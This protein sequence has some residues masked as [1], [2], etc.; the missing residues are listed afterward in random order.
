MRIISIALVLIF[1]KKYS[2][3][4]FPR[5]NTYWLA[6]CSF[7]CCNQRFVSQLGCRHL[8]P[9]TTPASTSGETSSALQVLSKGL[10]VRVLLVRSWA[11]NLGSSLL[12]QQF[13]KCCSEFFEGKSDDLVVQVNFIFEVKND[14]FE[15]DSSTIDMKESC[16]SLECL[17]WNIMWITWET[18]LEEYFDRIRKIWM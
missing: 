7:K 9:I 3:H 6:K 13:P 8:S 5:T 16:S 12:C 14:R 15:G 18:Y 17:G 10:V 11:L 1:F 2:F 4:V